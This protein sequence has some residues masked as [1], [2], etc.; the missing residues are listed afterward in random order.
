M[1]SY[2]YD[3]QDDPRFMDDER[4]ADRDKER[5]IDRDERYDDA[6]FNA[7]DLLDT[8]RFEDSREADKKD[9]D[10]KDD[11]KTD[12]LRDQDREE[13][14]GYITSD[15][16]DS[17]DDD[18]RDDLR[19]SEKLKGLDKDKFDRYNG[20]INESLNFQTRIFDER[21]TVR[22]VEDSIRNDVKLAF[23]ARLTIY[24]GDDSRQ[25]SLTEISNMIKDGK[26]D[27]PLVDAITRDDDRILIGRDTAKD[28]DR[29]LVDTQSVLDLLDE[30]SDL[31]GLD[32]DLDRDR[33][34]DD[35]DFFDETYG[36]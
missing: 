17:R 25:L 14:K 18:K 32:R 8:S 29:E 12:D 7:V 28:I 30:A 19:E 13:G 2:P 27:I 16:E 20:I 21:L 15:R 24:E 35:D 26:G 11:V 9:D 34:E 4:Y 31:Y 23:G 3:L 1:N 22:D 5:E 6:R 10:R 33:D 36:Y